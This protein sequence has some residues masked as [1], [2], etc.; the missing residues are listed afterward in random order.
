MPADR[1]GGMTARF[2]SQ[3]DAGPC[4]LIRIVSPARSERSIRKPHVVPDPQSHFHH[5]CVTVDKRRIAMASGVF[6]IL[7]S[8]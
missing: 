6:K 1:S 8:E 3:A 7:K 5:D 4:S 2:V